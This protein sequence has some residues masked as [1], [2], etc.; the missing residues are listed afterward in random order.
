MERF[1]NVSAG[2]SSVLSLNKVC[3]LGGPLNQFLAKASFMT[4]LT[5]KNSEENAVIFVVKLRSC[6]VFYM[7][8]WLL[9]SLE[10]GSYP[11]LWG[12]QEKSDT[13]ALTF[14]IL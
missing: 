3:L 9:T 8:S 1:L 2:S 5:I 12:S 11:L 13:R 4:H 6:M 14:S 7:H 10:L